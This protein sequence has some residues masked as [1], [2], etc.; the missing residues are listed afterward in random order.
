MNLTPCQ[1]REVEQIADGRIAHAI[2]LAYLFRMTGGP[3]PSPTAGEP[4]TGGGGGLSVEG[5]TTGDETKT[6]AIVSLPAPRVVSVR[7]TALLDAA[8]AGLGGSIEG[9]ATIH[10]PSARVI[11][12]ARRLAILDPGLVGCDVGIVAQG[13]GA[14]LYVRGTA[15]AG[16]VAW[17]VVIEI[18]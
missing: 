2:A 8:G 18:V 16:N 17:R 9:T 12:Q 14:G 1:A 13:P 6:L 7:F 5:S 3:S 10:K 15:G 11:G 4:L